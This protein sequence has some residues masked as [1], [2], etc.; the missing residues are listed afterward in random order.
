M[1]GCTYLLL[2]LKRRVLE[3]AKYSIIVTYSATV[4]LKSYCS[5][6]MQVPTLLHC[7]YLNFDP[8]RLRVL[9]IFFVFPQHPKQQSFLLSWNSSSQISEL[10]NETIGEGEVGYNPK[11]GSHSVTEEKAS[12]TFLHTRY[13]QISKL[14]ISKIYLSVFLKQNSLDN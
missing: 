6:I 5:K 12:C 2:L 4:S 8:R 11:L 13:I 14:K 9:K 1:R 7:S 10:I 3:V